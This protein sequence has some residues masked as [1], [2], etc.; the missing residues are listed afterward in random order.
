VRAAGEYNTWGIH[1]WLD[2]NKPRRYLT[3]KARQIS[4][5]CSSLVKKFKAMFS[6]FFH[7]LVVFFYINKISKHV[8]LNYYQVMYYPSSEATL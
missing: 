3:A 5:Q 1:A 8:K 2:S 7:H 6:I 4:D